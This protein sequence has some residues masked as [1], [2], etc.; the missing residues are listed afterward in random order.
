MRNDRLASQ[1][2]FLKRH[3]PGIIK[4]VRIAKDF[5][6]LRHYLTPDEIRYCHLLWEDI[7]INNYGDVYAC[8]HHLPGPLGNIYDSNLD[9][10]WNGKMMIKYRK[11]CLKGA[12]HCRQ[13]CYLAP[14][15]YDIHEK[16]GIQI[17]VQNLRRLWIL[18]GE[19]CNL[20]CIMCPQ[21]GQDKR[22]P[23][24]DFDKIKDKL[25]LA[26]LD[27]VTIQGGEPLFM[28]SAIEAFEHFGKMGCTVNFLTNGT[29]MT[30]K[31]AA[32]IIKYSKTYSVSVNA[33]CKETHEKINAGSNLERVLSNIQKVRSTSREL[34]KTI[35][36]KLHMTIIPD[37][38]REIPLFIRQAK[39][40]GA[41]ILDFGH[42]PTAI[43]LLGKDKALRRLL[44]QE[45]RAAFKATKGSYHETDIAHLRI[46]GFSLPDE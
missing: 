41:D 25:S 12:L 20:K 40:W 34:G 14:R 32:M 3:C 44:E 24:L 2:H 13:A 45:I 15:K 18:F 35:Q 46:M 5:F 23:V 38:I 4:L 31:L 22:V 42:D 36:I 33:G 16:P 27:A 30:D 7:F 1:A 26:H 21:L 8:C 39:E 10:I 9:E 29:I 28:P 6:R 43:K 11:R 19:R 37:N 17:P